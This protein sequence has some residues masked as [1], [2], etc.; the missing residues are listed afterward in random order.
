[1]EKKQIELG[2]E[3]ELAVSLLFKENGFWC[4][5]L[6][7]KLGGQPV[8]IVAGKGIPNSTN[9]KLWLV[10][11]KHLEEDKKSFPFSRIEPNQKTTLFYA[12]NYC[13]IQTLGFVICVGDDLTKFY[14]LSYEKYKTL[15][16]EG[17]K[18]VKIKDLQDFQ[19]VLNNE[20]CNR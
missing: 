10:D 17:K 18:S 14:F 6:S 2:D 1:M 12:K 15:E 13:N 8:D 4:H 20:S 7:K 11:A 3:T 9:C 5:I 16:E 19:E